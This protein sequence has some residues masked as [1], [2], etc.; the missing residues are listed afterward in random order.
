MIRAVFALPPNDSDSNLVNFDSQYGTKLLSFPSVRALITLPSVV[1]E[2]LIPLASFNVY[3]L[4][5]VLPTFSDP[6]R[7]TR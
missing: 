3:P 6:A 4:A 2:R 7:S 1:K 5:P